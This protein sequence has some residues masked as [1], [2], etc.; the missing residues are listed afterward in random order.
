MTGSEAEFKIFT[1]K[2]GKAGLTDGYV[3][4]FK[5]QERAQAEQKVNVLKKKF[6][7][8]LHATSMG[9]EDNAKL[10]KLRMTQVEE[11]NKMLM[12]KKFERKNRR[13]VKTV[14]K[15]KQYASD[16]EQNEETQAPV[17]ASKAPF[18]LAIN[19]IKT[20]LNINKNIMFLK[21]PL[22]NRAK[23]IKNGNSAGNRK[24]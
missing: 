2:E 21:P 14:K 7:L 5:D 15:V 17:Q 4:K 16:T 6:K 18:R 23:T 12:Y 24:A 22:M 10:K 20:P 13:T 9:N 8:T 3:S 19:K 11:N 1:D